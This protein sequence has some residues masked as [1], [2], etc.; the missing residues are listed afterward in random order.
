MRTYGTPANH[1]PTA[2]PPTTLPTSEEDPTEQEKS[3]D[4]NSSYTPQPGENHT[5][6]WPDNRRSLQAQ[7]QILKEIR[8]LRT[9]SQSIRTE[10]ANMIHKL[11]EYE[12]EMK[13]VP[14]EGKV[15]HEQTPEHSPPRPVRNQHKGIT[16]GITSRPPLP[17]TRAKE[18]E[19]INR[20]ERIQLNQRFKLLVEALKDAAKD[21]PKNERVPSKSV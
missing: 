10:M 8:C 7:G 18:R 14:P 15:R 2:D 6:R 17:D 20:R 21:T 4:S 1:R 3:K 5:T 9:A 11:R 13:D 19:E 16:H 12:E